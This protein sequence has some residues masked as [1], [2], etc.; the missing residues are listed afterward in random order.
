MNATVPRT[1]VAAVVSL[2]SGI[3]SWV[4][5]PF[6]GAIVAVV[7]GHVARADIHRAP[8]GSIDGD[9]MALAGLILGYLQLALCL[10]V[11]L[12]ILLFFGGLA[13]FASMGH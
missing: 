1:S 10:L 5:L 8:A 11:L 6:I 4:A 7:T 12:A 13:F 3:V 9:G 2:V